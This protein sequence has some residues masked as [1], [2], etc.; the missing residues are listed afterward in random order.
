MNKFVKYFGETLFFVLL[1]IILG[2][3]GRIINIAIKYNI[4]SILFF[5]INLLIAIFFLY[6]IEQHISSHFANQLHA[7]TAGAFFI[8][9]YFISL[10]IENHGVLNFST[11][12]YN[13]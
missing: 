11:I 3:T 4:P 9:T 5:F 12:R 13:F 6:I 10:E 1:G 2:M 8:F 7:S